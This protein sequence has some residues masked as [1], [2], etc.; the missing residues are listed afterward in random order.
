MS[1][2]RFEADAPLEIRERI[3]HR[4]GCRR[5]HHRF[6]ARERPRLQ[7]PPGGGGSRLHQRPPRATFRSD[8]VEALGLRLQERLL[9]EIDASLQLRDE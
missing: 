9:H 8:P 6:L 3:G 2:Q 7:F 1:A 5:E 4:K